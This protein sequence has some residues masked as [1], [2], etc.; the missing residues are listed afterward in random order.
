MQNTGDFLKVLLEKLLPNRAAPVIGRV[1]KAYE[2]PGKNKYAV[3]VR[4]VTAG[5]LEE[6]DQVIAEVPLNPIWVGKKGKGLY[7]IPPKDALVIIE[8]LQWNPAYPFVSGVWS[9]GYEAGEFKAGQLMITDGEGVKFGVDADALLL[10]AT[11]EQTL[12]KILE[13]L[14]D[15]ITGMQTI[16]APP[17]HDV[18]PASIQKLLAIKQDIAKLLKE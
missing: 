1:I 14:I 15:E 11:K 10:I 2:G 5:T 12:K 17:K 18:S 13:K 8:F 9:D 16:G 3:D 7:A 6:T 4:V